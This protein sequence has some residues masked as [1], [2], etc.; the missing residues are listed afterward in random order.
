ME[1]R[2]PAGSRHSMES[3]RQQ[4]ASSAAGHSCDQKSQ[5][6]ASRP[7]RA[8]G[9]WLGTT[10]CACA[11]SGCSSTSRLSVSPVGQHTHLQ[12]SLEVNLSALTCDSLT[13]VT[14]FTVDVRDR[15]LTI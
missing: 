11:S 1:G 2:R 15:T 4:K 6:P 9:S 13:S 3:N 10:R 8:C 14:A 7:Q 12:C 5:R